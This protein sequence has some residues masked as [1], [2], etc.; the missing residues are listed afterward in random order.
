MDYADVVLFIKNAR[1]DRK[2]DVEIKEMLASGGWDDNDIAESFKLADAKLTLSGEMALSGLPNTFKEPEQSKGGSLPQEDKPVITGA[3]FLANTKLDSF[4]GLTGE[5]RPMSIMSFTNPEPEV[6]K[7]SPALFFS[8]VIAFFLTASGAGAYYFGID[9]WPFGGIPYK[10]SEILGKAV[11]KQSKIESATYNL[12]LTL[13]SEQRESGARM[14]VWS[15]E[16]TE[17]EDAVSQY[18]KKV[19]EADYWLRAPEDI[20]VFTSV[21]GTLYLGKAKENYKNLGGSFLMD[22]RSRINNRDYDLGFESRYLDDSLFARFNRVPRFSGMLSMFDLEKIR[23]LWLE[24]KY[25]SVKTLE[26]LNILKQDE[27]RSLENRKR[28]KRMLEILRDSNAIIVIGE[29]QKEYVTDVVAYKY[30]LWFD[31]K[32]INE[33]IRRM[34]DEGIIGGRAEDSYVF[35]PFKP[36]DEIPL[37]SSLEFRRYMNYLKELNQIDLWF[38]TKGYLVQFSWKSKVIPPDDLLGLNTI[39]YTSLLKL[40][41]TNINNPI[42]IERPRDTI[43][44]EE[45]I[46]MIFTQGPLEAEIEELI[47]E[48]NE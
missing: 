27:E 47:E 31:E 2:S 35:N 37:F 24:V 21:A 46:G 17:G 29:P 25:P 1:A 13:R 10:N 43:S 7:K 41:L 23:G 22:S 16:V 45:A 15:D 33:A 42:Q 36:S 18:L 28:Q 44:L 9:L 20:D 34:V 48:E 14:F 32:A 11:F 12:T 40:T 26:N 19:N 8:I 30:S 6:K 4:S 39:Q 38:D 3:D 5:E